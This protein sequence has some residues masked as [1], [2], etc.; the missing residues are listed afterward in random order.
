M[1]IREVVRTILG[2]T[3][4]RSRAL[5]GTLP[6]RE[7][8]IGK[9]FANIERAKSLLGWTSQTSLVDGLNKTVAWIHENPDVAVGIE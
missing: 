1:T 7:G 3:G 2:I 4:S 5:F 9:V 6:D 8:E